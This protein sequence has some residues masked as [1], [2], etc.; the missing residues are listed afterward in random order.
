MSNKLWTRPRDSSKWLGAGDGHRKAD[1]PDNREI[2]AFKETFY[3]AE[4]RSVRTRHVAAAPLCALPLP[5][6]KMSLIKRY[7]QKRAAKN[8]QGATSGL[9]NPRFASKII[10]RYAPSFTEKKS[11][12]PKSL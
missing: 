1:A 2:A 5:M 7:N 3:L 11:I 12:T 6:A 8:R 9:R 10:R 4:N